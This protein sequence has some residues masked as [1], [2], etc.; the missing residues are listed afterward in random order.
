MPNKQRPMRNWPALRKIMSPD[1][2]RAALPGACSVTGIERIKH[3]LTNESW[4]VHTDADVIVVRVSTTAE[5]SLQ[6][7]R[8][9]ET[10]ILDAV[11]RAGIGP[12]VLLCDPSRHLLITRYI[13]PTWSDEDAA[14]GRN[15]GR[16]AALLR[17]LHALTP[18]PGLRSVELASVIDGYL[19]TL[20]TNAV[21]SALG[22]VALRTKARNIAETLRHD[23]VPQ[24]CHND[25]HALNIVNSIV[26][27]IVDTAGGEPALRLIDWEYAG[28][29]ETMFDLAS[30]CVYHRYDKAQRGQL[31][32]AYGAGADSA[33][34]LELACWLFE[35][36]RDLWMEVRSL[37]DR[38][39]G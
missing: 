23:S 10:L 24:L 5:A 18:P 27:S 30:L 22:T 2:V 20:D 21:H 25:I 8:A 12:E 14:R 38:G 1:E 26:D 17:R 28:L 34:R 33:Q 6:I 32:S 39:G 19:N 36:I 4:L 15:I 11:A 35:Y 37:P 3:G 16:I 31:L 13:G 7:D 9:S 29:G